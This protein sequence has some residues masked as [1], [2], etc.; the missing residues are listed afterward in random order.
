MKI[1]LAQLES[2]PGRPD[3]NCAKLL[4]YIPKAIEAKADMI[5][6]PE[7]FIPGYLIGDQWEELSFIEDCEGYNRDIEEASKEIIVVY[8]NIK[9]GKGIH[10]D[11]RPKLF[12]VINWVGPNLH[13]TV[14]HPY[15]I[16]ALLPNY[17]EFDEP[18][19]FTSSMELYSADYFTPHTIQ[20]TE[21]AFTVCEDLWCETKGKDYPV[22]PVEEFVKRGAQLIINCSCSPYTYEK[23]KARDR[24]FGQGHA[25]AKKTPLIYLNATGLQNVG[26]SVYTFDGSSVAYNS[27]GEPVFQA[28]MFEEGLYYVEYKNNNLFPVSKS[29]SIPTGS[30][31]TV[32]AMKYGFRKFLELCKTNKVV[33]G[34]S[35]G[36]DSSVVAS[37]AAQVV[38]PENLLLVNMPTRWNSK[39]TR[40]IAEELAKN[41]GCY[42]TIIPIESSVDLTKQYIDGLT[43]YQQ[44]KGVKVRLNS[45]TGSYKALALTSFDL[46]N[47]QARDRSSRILA[48]LASAWGGVFTCNSNKTESCVGYCTLGGD[49][50]GFFAPLGDLW[51]HQVYEIGRELNEIKNYI[52]EEAFTVTPS[53]ELSSEQNVDEGKGD[54]LIYW[55]HDKLFESW[56]QWW[57]RVTPEENLQWY[58]DKTINE[59]LGT[60]ED[61]YKLFPTVKTFTDDLERWY[62]LFKGMSVVKRVQAP[63]ILGLTRRVFGWDF[64]DYI[65]EAYFTK[66]YH[67]LKNKALNSEA[68]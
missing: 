64:R 43:V 1:A 56:Q 10:K 18:R 68:K 7:L 60:S 4:E 6:A 63:P 57:Y 49:N 30:K 17:R 47:V 21:I 34:V 22:C 53:A 23:N 61:V 54:P 55:Y 42:Y 48:A 28:P 3:L 11:G 45:S 58:L 62:K 13:H 41:I 59:K 33:V 65:G 35:G 50:S 32:A 40:N 38:G 24:V 31:E 39:T 5:I 66:K 9:K 44:E 19:H 8:G 26:K 36:I 20:G 12:N 37:L 25:K 15:Y 51:K 14:M 16:K 29:Y 67:E 27:Y 52:P 2:V 46:E